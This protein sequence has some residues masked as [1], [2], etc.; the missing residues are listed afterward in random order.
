MTDAKEAAD[1]LYG[2]ALDE[3]TAAR[4]ELAKTL[5]GEGE[6]EAAAEVATLRKPSRPAW[7][8][9][10][11]ARDQPELADAVLDAAAGLAE[12]QEAV[13]SG[14]GRE[15]LDDAVRAEREA[16]D[17]M[18]AAVRTALDEAGS[19]S[20]AMV[21][22]A[23]KT[24]H[25]VPGDPELQ[26]ELASARVVTDREP[27]GFGAAPAVSPARRRAKGPERPAKDGAAT[28]KPSKGA[29]KKRAKPKES[30]AER[31]RRAEEA[32][33]AKQQLVEARRRAQRAERQFGKRERDLRRA[34]DRLDAAREELG[35]AEDQVAE[36]AEDL[37]RRRKEMEDARAVLAELS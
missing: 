24:L 35:K 25:A 26:E 29:A 22:R 2:L 7:A 12:A 6:K 34:L 11:V 19:G 31:E 28:G 16:V 37:Q 3:F 32:R 13:V 15:T 21:D 14:S 20:E 8:I 17:E 33:A 10:R 18:V 23:R 5:R 4:N 30:A 27:V 9:N 1:D 36:L